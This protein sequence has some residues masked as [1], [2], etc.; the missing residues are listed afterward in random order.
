MPLPGSEYQALH[1]DYSRPLFA[2]APEMA[3]PVYMLV[4]SF[5]PPEVPSQDCREGHAGRSPRATHAYL[6]I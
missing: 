3:L 1:A 6:T 2:E 4:V 5:G